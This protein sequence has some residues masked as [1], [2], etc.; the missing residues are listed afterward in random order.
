MD[1]E[2]AALLKNETW[3]LVPCRPGANII[4]CKWVYKIKR[5]AD[6]SIDRYKARLVAKGFKQCYGI[7]YE[8]TFSLVVKA[9]T[10][11]LILSV[12]VSRGW[13]IRQLDVQNVFL[14][15]VLEE[16]VYMR[17]PPRYESKEASHLV[18]KLY[19]A[20]Y[21]LKQ[22]PRAWYSRLSSKLNALGF[23]SSKS[24]TSL[25]FYNN[26]GITMFV[27]VYVDDVIVVRSSLEATSRLLKNLEKELA[28]KDLGDLHYFLGIEV[29]KLPDGLLLS[30]N[31]YALDILRRV[32][33]TSCKPAPTPLS[34]SEK[35]SVHV[36]E[37][38][39]P[40][41][42]TK[43][44]SIVGGLQYL[45][46]TRPNL[47]FSVNKVYQYLHCPTTVHLIAVKRILR[48]VKGTID[49]G[50]KIVKSSSNLV[51]GFSDVDWAGC[52]DDRRSIERFAIF[53]GSNLVSWNARKQ[54]TVSRSSTEAEYKALA[55]AIAEI[56]WLQSPL[57]ELG[58]VK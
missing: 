49:M 50:L 48:F 43:Y 58:L 37:V 26:Q 21:G 40:D 31:K 8:D 22:A 36:G 25:F 13:S 57:A 32:G 14:H 54:P 51:S 24:D 34:T 16:E 38:L 2:Y 29:T 47:A 5:K 18:C 30:Q 27:L 45:T 53:F 55:N 44:R 10:I 46:L 11:R 28:L 6:G 1:Q 20:V 19:K 41:D 9:A 3:H 42:A 35:L 56:M 23:H 33:M 39:G 4:D 12:G 17:Q 7:D 52:L 15:G